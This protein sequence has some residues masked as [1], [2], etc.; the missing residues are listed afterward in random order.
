MIY[1][2]WKFIL[3]E[4]L[5]KYCQSC[6]Q[7]IPDT[8]N[9]CPT[10]GAPQNSGYGGF[11]GYG[12][13]RGPIYEVDAPSR[14]LA[15]VGFFFPV[16]GLI[17]YLYWRRSMPL[18]ARSAGRGALAGVILQI[19]LEIIVVILGYVLEIDSFS[20]ELYEF[21]KETVFVNSDLH[22]CGL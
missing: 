19:A 6:G 22:F 11:G 9:F 20:Y 16:V 10:C 3:K 21:A 14:L 17:M 13:G 18:K 12:D 2:V 4:L 15:F 8:A 5:M 7:Q 1:C